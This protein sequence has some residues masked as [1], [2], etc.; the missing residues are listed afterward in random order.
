MNY[1]IISD[2]HGNYEALK[3][4]MN[5]FIEKKI[6]I[7]INCGD[8]VGY[9]PRPNECVGFVRDSK[10]MYNVIGNHDLAVIGLKDTEN[11]NFIAQEAVRW[12]R[13]RLS[14]ININFLNTLDSKSYYSN[15]MFIHGSPRDPLNEYIFS[16]AQALPNFKKMNRPICFGGHTHSPA[17]FY[18]NVNGDAKTILFNHK[19]SIEIRKDSMYIINVGSVGQPRDG[20]PLACACIFNEKDM[21]ISLYRVEYDIET[22]RKDIIA[23]GLPRFL[24]ERLLHGI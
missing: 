18:L 24:A 16:T 9:G 10:E 20:D 15:F 4:V 6:H 11:F 14:L 3:A 5:F 17:C 12:T 19:N 2:I 8:I 23:A 7:I 13:D 1:G 22:T 21:Q